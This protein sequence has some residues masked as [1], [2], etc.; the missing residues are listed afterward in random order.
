MEITKFLCGFFFDDFWH[1]LQLIVIVAVVLGHPVVK[2]NK[3]CT[4][5]EE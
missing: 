5:K 2:I 1:Y 3:I 4:K